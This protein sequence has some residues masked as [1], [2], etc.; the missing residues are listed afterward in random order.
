MHLTLRSSYACEAKQATLEIYVLEIHFLLSMFHSFLIYFKNYML[1]F[2]F[3]M[4]YFMK[5]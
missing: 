5:Q 1:V 3:D 4:Q 2:L